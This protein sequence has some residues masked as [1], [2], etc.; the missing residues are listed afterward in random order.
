M[1]VVFLETSAVVELSF[2]DSKTNSRI[3]ALIEDY[4]S[5]AS[6]P[7]VTFEIA[8]GFLRN[9]ILLHNKTFQLSEFAEIFQYTANLRYKP[10]YLGTVLGCFADYFRSNHGELTEEDRLLHFR[11]HMSR[12][13]RRGW[14]KVLSCAGSDINEVG[15][16]SDIG[17]PYR[18]EAELLDQDTPKKE[19]G[20]N[21]ACGVKAFASENRAELERI[22]SVLGVSDKQDQETEKRVKSIR[23]LYRN[24]K[25]NFEAKHCYA[26]SDLLIAFDAVGCDAILTKNGKHFEPMCKELGLLMIAY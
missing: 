19:C 8:R 13:I 11:A 22:R 23:E 25:R 5:T 16:R 17:N 3:L 15:C 18:R 9:L 12:M 26:S 7:Y 10:H 21:I 14:K 2:W 1:S 24:P 20:T 6:S 4:E